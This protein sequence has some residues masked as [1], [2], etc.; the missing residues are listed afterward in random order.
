MG[1]HRVP[2]LR[3][4]SHM[5]VTKILPMCQILACI[6]CSPHTHIHCNKG[7]NIV[8]AVGWM[9]TSET[10]LAPGQEGH[11]LVEQSFQAALLMLGSVLH[12]LKGAAS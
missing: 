4:P 5:L 1:S 7:Q 9:G 8:L 3:V 2:Y 10:A 6:K 12:L 11:I